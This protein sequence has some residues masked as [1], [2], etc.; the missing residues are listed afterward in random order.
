MNKLSDYLSPGIQYI[1]IAGLFFAVM[2]IIIKELTQFHLFQIVFFRSGITSLVA[3]VYLKR[4]NISLL[5]N[6]KRLLILRALFGV[7][8]MTLF[9]ATIQR[10]PLGAAV[11]LKYLSPVFTAIFAVVWLKEKVVA[12]Q[13]VLFGVAF[14]GVFIL[15]GFDFRIDPLNLLLGLT[16]AVFAGLVYV[17]IRKIGSSE[18]SMVIINYFMFTA[19]VL[20]GLAMIP[21]WQTP[22]LLELAA[23]LSMGTLGY[24]AQVF[25]TRALQIEAASRV[26]PFRYLEVVY[27]LLL[28][29]LFFSEG[30]TMLSFLGIVL[31]VGSMVVNVFLKQPGA[32]A[33]AK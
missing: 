12:I 20:A 23:L 22:N 5:G 30:Y 15:K 10:I 13:W 14:A 28:G 6:K 1:I 21:F 4:N 27:S 24:F 18:H 26:A 29:F 9:F 32:A 2:Q 19:S 3:I 7:I 25:M 17:T 11:S 16:G 8:A 31:I 33:G